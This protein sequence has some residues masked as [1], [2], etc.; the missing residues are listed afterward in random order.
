MPGLIATR[1]TDERHTIRNVIDFRPKGFSLV[2]SFFVG[3][4]ITLQDIE[5][6]YLGKEIEENK[7][8]IVKKVLKERMT[9]D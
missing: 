3:T 2:K 5:A 7:W 8:T 1:G 4:I 6:I 9:R